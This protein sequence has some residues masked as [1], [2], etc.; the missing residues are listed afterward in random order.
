M[1]IELA[2]QYYLDNF[3]QL[4]DFVGE[5]YWHLLNEHERAY[6]QRLTAL[7]G[8]A[9]MLYVR[10]LTRRGD[11]F[12]RNKLSYPEIVD[13]DLAATALAQQGLL[14]N[15]ARPS[16]AEALPLFTKAQLVARV[17]DV[18]WQKLSRADLEQT[19]LEAG[20]VQPDLATQLCGEDIVYRALDQT[21][22][23]TYRLCFFGN[24]RQDLTDFVLRDLGMQRYENYPLE[25][26]QLLFTSRA[27]LDR[28]LHFYQVT[29]AL[30]QTLPLERDSLLQ[31]WRA[32][33]SREHGDPLLTRR[34][35]RFGNSVARQLERS[36]DLDAA[37]GIYGEITRPPARERT[38]RIMVK[39]GA[40]EAGLAL[41]RV[42]KEQPLNE[43]ERQFANSF[44]YRQGKKHGLPWP[45]PASYEPPRETLVLPQSDHVESAVATCLAAD[46]ECY[47]V[48]NALANGVLGLL[49]WDIVFA[50]LRGAFFNPFQYAP[51][52]FY[53]PEF[54]QR[55][56]GLLDARLAEIDDPDAMAQR[57]WQHY[58]S[59]QGIANP[60]V[61]WQVLV[62]ALLDTALSRIPT[63]HW[64]AL[65]QRLLADLRHHRNGMP[66]LLHFPASG[67]YRWVEVKG[68]GD[69]LQKNQLRWMAFFAEQDMPHQVVHVRWQEAGD[70]NA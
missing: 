56:K 27:Q 30:D 36:G 48:E 29:D 25:E 38:A 54:S 31:L 39:Q 43:E 50:P 22:F 46:G 66:D 59:K 55:R 18:G 15:P 7:P 61:N 1:A 23:T 35:E 32:M 64:R 62:P 67:G 34:V 33:P 40:V 20:L 41:C 42:M 3:R 11:L 65:F 44:G 13:L 8:A 49:I 58:T 6:Y 45:T 28:H 2:P 52:D 60:L 69:R 51:V 57:I 53:E 68:P 26:E 37:L 16:L 24:L 4:L 9:Q 14:E 12:L 5:R 47:Y 17:G 63:S 10:L 70:G 21:L 19:V